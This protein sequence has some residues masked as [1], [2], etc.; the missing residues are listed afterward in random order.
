MGADGCGILAVW[1]NCASGQEAV[2]EAWYREEHLPERV[3]VPGFRYGR[4][5]ESTGAGPRYFTYYETDSPAV[6]TSP[7]YV[8]R[9]QAPTA[10]TTAIMSGVFID[11][12]RTVCRRTAARGALRGGVVV[13]AR[14]T[15]PADPAALAQSVDA[16]VEAGALRAEAWVADEPPTRTISA[17]EAIRG[18]DK[19]ITACLL[20]EAGYEAE[21]ARIA[22]ALARQFGARAEIGSYRFLCSLAHAEM[23]V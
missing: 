4:R 15:D 12:T 6:L 2:Y 20:V 14:F 7:A 22:A 21:A 16:V 5:Y 18:A 23:S 9:L 3:G 19:K 17:E 10:R 1:N 11:M 8:A 13:A